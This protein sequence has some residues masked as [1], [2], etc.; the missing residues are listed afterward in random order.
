MDAATHGQEGGVVWEGCLGGCQQGPW[1]GVDGTL[2]CAALLRAP[3]PCIA[4]R[5]LMR[6]SGDDIPEWFAFKSVVAVLRGAQ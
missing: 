6:R 3:R 1:R 4:R 2:A 5:V